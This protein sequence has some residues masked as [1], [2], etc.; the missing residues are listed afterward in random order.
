M[1]FANG[2]VVYSPSDLITF[3][4]SEYASWMDRLYL[5]QPGFA[6]AD[7]V[8]DQG[9][10]IMAAGVE[11]EKHV[12]EMLATENS[13]THIS[14][15]PDRGAATLRAMA[16]GAP[17]IYQAYLEHGEF[18]GL[19]DFLIRTEGASYLGDYH[20]EVWDAKLGQSMKPHYAV[21]L[22]CYAEIL[23][24]VQGHLATHMGI[25]LA[26]GERRRLRVR[27]FYYYY[28]V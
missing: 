28:R 16:T 22:C 17:I 27:D 12:L 7:G 4:E 24:S 25:F 5:E 10:M 14:S 9:R 15:G 21:Q 1:H 11:H 23:A 19:A 13:I 18:M 20:Y 6:L 2:S 8:D 3:I 26:N